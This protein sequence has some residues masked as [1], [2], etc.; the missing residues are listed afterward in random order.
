MLFPFIAVWGFW[1]FVFCLIEF[2]A[3]VAL[4]ENE[5]PGWAT[6]SL[7]LG[8]VILWLFSEINVF[9]YIFEHPFKSFFW[10]LG[11]TVIGFVW[12]IFKL[13]FKR[14]KVDREH[15]QGKRR[16]LERHTDKNEEDYLLEHGKDIKYRSGVDRNWDSIIAWALCWPFSMFWTFLSD[17]IVRLYEEIA[18]SLRGV[19]ERIDRFALRNVIKDQEKYKELM[20]EKKSEK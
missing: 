1:F 17:A 9:T 3:L 19:Y 20:K 6:F 8:L 7:A 12:S 2:V 16:W 14:K 15:M 13:G 10:F 11:Y 5:R 4:A 18:E